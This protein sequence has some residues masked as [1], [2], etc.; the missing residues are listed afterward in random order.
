MT[1]EIEHYPIRKYLEVDK[2]V[3]YCKRCKV[4]VSLSIL[5]AYEKVGLLFP[6]YRLV[7]P[8]EYVRE[9]FEFNN[10]VPFDPNIPFD[11]DGKW[12][13]INELTGALSL[14]TLR[15]SLYFKQTQ[16]NGHP[17]DYAYE[18]NNKF[19]SKPSIDNFKP[20]EEYKITVETINGQTIKENTVDHYYSPWQIFIADELNNK[21]VIIE[22]YITGYKEY[23]GIKKK[24]I[25]HSSLLEFADMFQAVSNFR[26]MESLI[27][28]DMTSDLKESVVEGEIFETLTTKIAHSAKN[29]YERHPHIQ[30]IKFIRKLVEI[31][32]SY[33]E[34]ERIKL[35]NEF[36]FFLRS[37]I[38][39]LID[40]NKKSF[41][42][43][44]N[45]YDGKFKGIMSQCIEENVMVYPGMLQQIFPD[46]I[47]QS[48][49]RSSWQIERYLNELNG[50][51][52]DN[53]KLSTKIKDDLIDSIIEGGH[54]I[55]LSHVHEIQELWFNRRLHWTSSIWAHI[56]SFAISIES[57]GRV[58]F[59]Q[60]YLGNI[61]ETAFRKDYT[62]LRDS[63]G[64][65][66][67]DAEKPDEYIQKL[68]KILK[69]KKEN[70]KG[71][72]GHHLVIAH[73][74]RN[75]LSHNVQF[76]PEMLGSLFV[77]VYKSL[78]FTL[79]CLFVSKSS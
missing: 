7:V 23:W 21:H 75:Y 63:I 62:S 15:R 49:E 35:S 55:L 1:V 13:E 48:K 44:S 8:D 79:I 20:W 12:Q 40:A 73:L 65:E 68:N 42:E 3:E 53:S 70:I 26:M 61:L 17:L 28:T 10:R 36:M 25:H 52:P 5:E 34:R 24:I 30:W 66:I 9:V 71:I 78:V 14:Y 51:L 33:L 46:E 22:N 60:N 38:S 57:L 58:W 69:H 39:I 4:E 47:K 19:L 67:T 41:E 54:E 31:H 32:K 16:E 11:V 56:R 29:E 77:E 37:T 74:T 18:C 43:I 6:I 2:F 64:A 27:W 59:D 72:C 45:E 50:L 76:E